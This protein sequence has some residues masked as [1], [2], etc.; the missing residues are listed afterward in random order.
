MPPSPPRAI[1]GRVLTFSGDPA[2]VGAEASHR[3]LEDGQFLGWVASVRNGE[4]PNID[5]GPASE[6]GP[7]EMIPI[8][9][10]Q[11]H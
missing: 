9:E 6:G 3:Y 8:E 4:E 5:L 1:R 10:S 11:S 7:T 2:E